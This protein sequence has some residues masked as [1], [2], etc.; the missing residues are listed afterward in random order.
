MPNHDLTP[1]QA[2]LKD[3]FDELEKTRKIS[4]D[5]LSDINVQ[6]ISAH[7]SPRQWIRSMRSAINLLEALPNKEEGLQ[8]ITI[9]T[10]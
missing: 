1:A 9:P 7:S 6:L 8:E 5:D 2:T 10:D 3:R 4:S